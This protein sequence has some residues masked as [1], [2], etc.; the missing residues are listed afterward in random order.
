MSSDRLSSGVWDR[1][2]EYFGAHP[3]PGGWV[4]RVWAPQARCVALAG[5][6]TGWQRWDMHRLEDG[7]WEL[8]VE[9]ARQ[10]EAYQ[11]IVTRQDGQEVWKSDPY[12]FH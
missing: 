4:F 3:V 12:G 9:N 11:Y 8:T 2:Y 6:F 1:A 10:F 5:D 7:V